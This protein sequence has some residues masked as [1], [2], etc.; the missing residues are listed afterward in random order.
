MPSTV[1]RFLT[2]LVI[3]LFGATQAISLEISV[4][5]PDAALEGTLRDATLTS[6]LSEE[7]TTRPI[8]VLSAA[9]ADYARL[10]AILYEQGYFS[11]EISI[12]VDGR[13]A[14]SLS[15]V[16]TLPKIKQVVYLVD[17]GPQ[18]TFGNLSINP[19]SPETEPIAGYEAGNVARISVLRTATR[20]EIEG[21]RQQG[22]A[23]T[24]VADQKITARH[25]QRKLDAEVIL[26]TGP[27]LRFGKLYFDSN[28]TV[29]EQR[30]RE[31]AG[32][33]SGETFDPDTID[34]VQSRLRRTGTFNVA[35]LTEAEVANTDG[36]LDVTA[37]ISDQLPRRYSLGVEYGIND[38]FGLL[39]SWMH[40]NFFGG[41]ETLLVE[42]QIT[43]WL[44]DS[45]DI[46]YQLGTRLSRP[47][48]FR[49]DLEMYVG[50]E[51]VQENADEFKARSGTFEIGGIYFA[52]EEL[53]YGFGLALKT[54]ETKDDRGRLD[55]TT[56]ELP[57]FATLDRRDDDLDATSGYYANVELTPFVATSGTDSGMISR[58]DLRTYQKVGDSVTFAVRGQLGSLVGPSLNSAPADL[59]FYSGGGGT[60]RGQKYQ[61]LGV[62]FG[63]VGTIGGRS[64]IGLSGEIRVRTGGK[65]S[66]VGFYDAGYIGS[67]TFPDASSGRWHT[68][69]GAGLRYDTG[70][71]PIRADIAFPA[72]GPDDNSGPEIYIGIGQAF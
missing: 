65:I 51:F 41:A 67:E 7:D 12:L 70:I 4:R 36:T 19:A 53:T 68:G 39:G 72:S 47:A 8:N 44:G 20:N 33:Q 24:R 56:F 64:F 59:L 42:G 49:T 28:S 1:L 40:R 9:Q 61:S 71:G 21:W 5:A 63:S 66:V 22:F 26:D 17:P 55:Y 31:I 37:T 29:S 2:V 6:S 30:L 48:T 11:P 60:V 45:G 52:S 54:A 27:R 50:A 10:I 69:V 16:A 25:P 18:F 43:G 32:W 46:D 23:K 15:P 38:G 35:T 13:E 57:L 58:L 62:D 14:A 3:A 34:K